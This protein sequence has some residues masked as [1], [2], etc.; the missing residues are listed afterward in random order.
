MNPVNTVV[1][2]WTYLVGLLRAG[3][4]HLT[5]GILGTKDGKLAVLCPACPCPGVNLAPEWETQDEYVLFCST[6]L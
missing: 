3:R 1:R 6:V 2:Q 4:A 5:D